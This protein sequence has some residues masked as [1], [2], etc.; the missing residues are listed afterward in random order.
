VMKASALE[1]AEERLRRE[2]E[3]R[4]VWEQPAQELELEKNQLTARL[5]ERENRLSDI[6][7][8]LQAP[9]ERSY[10][11]SESVDLSWLS[12][13]LVVGTS[14]N[15]EEIDIDATLETVR[16][17]FPEMMFDSAITTVIER[18]SSRRQA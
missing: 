9:R 14:A 4:A 6:A 2:A 15:Q 16:R 3:E 12:D 18:R 5:A 11:P 1:S 10:R 17:H 8:R 7:P 13:R